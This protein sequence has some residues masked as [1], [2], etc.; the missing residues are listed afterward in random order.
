[1]HMIFVKTLKRTRPVAGAGTPAAIAASGKKPAEVKA[2][3]NP[4]WRQSYNYDQTARSSGGQFATNVGGQTAREAV[5][6][7]SPEDYSAGNAYAGG[8]SIDQATLDRLG[9]AGLIVQ[10]KKTGVVRM[11][12][13]ARKALVLGQA[14]SSAI[15]AERAEKK[16]QEAEAAANQKKTDAENKKKE[17]ESKREKDKQAREKQKAQAVVDKENAKIKAVKD[18]VEAQR[19]DDEVKKQTLESTAIGAGLSSPE[20]TGLMN[21]VKGQE[22]PFGSAMGDRLMAYGFLSKMPDEDAYTM[23]ASASPFMNA[24]MSGN[25]RGAKD[26]IRIARAQKRAA[27]AKVPIAAPVAGITTPLQGEAGR[28]IVPEKKYTPVLKLKP[29]VKELSR[30]IQIVFPSI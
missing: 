3:S 15:M 25:L 5:A 16:K 23:G 20:L 29:A 26:I 27:D 2:A 14:S 11:S 6:G 19:R 8:A 9:K 4:N 7:L 18:K 13:E 17:A 12:S 22:I 10:D 1:M 21:F 24:A 28:I 30:K